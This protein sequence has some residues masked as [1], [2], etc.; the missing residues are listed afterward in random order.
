MSLEL[1]DH[2]NDEAGL[3]TDHLGNKREEK[4]IFRCPRRPT[5]LCHSIGTFLQL[6]NGRNL[7]S[8]LSTRLTIPF[9]SQRLSKQHD[10]SE[11]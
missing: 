11:S 1:I 6:I 10:E 8:L 2:F 9:D 3:Q 7:V 5:P 4:M